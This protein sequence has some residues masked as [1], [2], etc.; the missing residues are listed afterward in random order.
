VVGRIGVELLRDGPRGNGQ[1][2][3]PRGDLDR[4]EVLDGATYERFDLDRDFYLERLLEP[5]F[6][7]ASCEAASGAS[8]S[9][10]AHRSQAS[11]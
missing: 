6:G 10:S 4:L 8:S 2:S 9:A 7:A 5:P 11:Q 1:G 3:P